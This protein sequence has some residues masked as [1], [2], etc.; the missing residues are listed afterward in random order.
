[1]SGVLLVVPPFHTERWPSI[2]VSP[3]KA[4]LGRDGIQCDLLYLNLR[5]AVLAG[6][7]LYSE[8][9]D[10]A[11]THGILIGDWIFAGDL[12]GDAVPDPSR[13]VDDIVRGQYSRYY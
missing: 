3:L 7:E 2:A 4:A 6:L 12:F 10:E 9:A 11:Q 8:M 5:F 13:Y 1:M